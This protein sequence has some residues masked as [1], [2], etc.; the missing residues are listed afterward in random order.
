MFGPVQRAG[1]TFYLPAPAPFHRATRS[2]IRPTPRCECGLRLAGAT[3]AAPIVLIVR[4]PVPGRRDVRPQPTQSEL[5][6]R[7][8]P[9]AGLPIGIVVL[10]LRATIVRRMLASCKLSLLCALMDQARGIDRKDAD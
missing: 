10:R 9:D 3:A 4:C 7:S 8:A 6:R 5:L 2:L 1:V